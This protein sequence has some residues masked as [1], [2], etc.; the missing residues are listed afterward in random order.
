MFINKFYL[1][2]FI[3]TSNS[4]AHVGWDAVISYKSFAF[5]QTASFDYW[6]L[7]H[8]QLVG[9]E[10]LSPARSPHTQPRKMINN[11]SRDRKSTR[12]NSSHT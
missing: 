1:K 3:I 4:A 11:V 8:D 10:P 5:F 9:P 2:A 7:V 12:L 6:L